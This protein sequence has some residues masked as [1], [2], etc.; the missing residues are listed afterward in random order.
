M[1][2]GSQPERRAGAMQA[3]VL[4]LT[5][6]I[7]VVPIMALAPNLPQLLQHFALTAN[8]DFLV[9]MIITLP[10]LAIVLLAP[11]AGALADRFGRR[12]LLLLALALFTA[13]GLLPLTLDSLPAI[14][15]AQCGVGIAE[16]IIITNANAML[17]DYFA[18]DQ[19]NRWLGLQSILGPFLTAAIAISAGLLGTLSWRAPF[20]TN[21]I[22]GIAFV[23]MWIATWEPPSARD[24][25]APGAIVD[26]AARPG[27]PWR[28]MLPVY[29]VTLLCGLVFY[30]PAI[31]MGLVFNDLG[32]RSPA[33]I[34]TLTTLANFASVASGYYFGRQ[35]RGTS[36][37]LALMFACFGVGLIGMSY[38]SSYAA[39]MPFALIVNLGVGLTLPLLIGW[40]LRSLEPVFRG[41][42]MGLW[43]SSFFSAQFICP[44]V[45]ALLIRRVGTLSTAVCLA[46]GA[47]LLLA[48]LCL[49]MARVLPPQATP[50]TSH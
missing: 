12:R 3:L 18:A 11:V 49:G 33:L 43:M 44:V 38:S 24:R 22:G 31:H 8:R 1:R 23:W 29:A 17:G 5:I 30:V 47:A 7:P 50:A 27:F 14:L 2:D 4:V 32:A 39:S 46:G 26:D 6:Q 13:C 21:L 37:N 16:A 40:T 19:R 35:R 10:S 9:P 48:L 41:R 36:E 25:P 42:G 28:R 45:F 20:A 15:W 34:A